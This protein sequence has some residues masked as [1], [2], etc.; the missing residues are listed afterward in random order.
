M[1]VTTT[2]LALSAI[3][4]PVIGAAPTQEQWRSPIPRSQKIFGTTSSSVTVAGAG[5]EQALIVTAN[6]PEGSAYVLVESAVS[7]VGADI[8][9][10]QPSAFAALDDS[11]ATPTYRDTFVAD[12]GA[13]W[14][15]GVTALGGT[16][17]CHECPTQIVIP[18]AMDGGQLT[19][20]IQN[21]VQDGVV[22]TCIAFFRFLVFDL[23]QAYFYGVNTPM[24]TR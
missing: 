1:T 16:Y 17:R 9:D 3:N 11:V 14:A 13:L 2:T 6:L 8:A 22:M 24:L 18:S 21:N 5:N 19:Y 23:N 12:R 15:T 20:W 4:V 10:W 7:L